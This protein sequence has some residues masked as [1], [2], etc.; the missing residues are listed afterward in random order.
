[1]LL[2]LVEVDRV[3]LKEKYVLATSND[4]TGSTSKLVRIIGELN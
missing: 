1:M 4:Y 2:S 3:E